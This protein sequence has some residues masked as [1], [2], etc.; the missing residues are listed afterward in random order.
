LQD[1]REGRLVSGGDNIGV[2]FDGPEFIK[3]TIFDF[4]DDLMKLDI[5]SIEMVFMMLR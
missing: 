2:D 4:K 1:Q 5:L 3:A